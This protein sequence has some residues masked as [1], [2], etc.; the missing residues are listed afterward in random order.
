MKTLITLFFFVVIV[1]LANAQDQ[2]ILKNGNEISAKV[3]EVNL[4][5]IK[6]KKFDNLNGP[7]YSLQKS[8]IFM[9]K[10][11]NGT[12]DVINNEPDPKNQKVIAP[13]TPN[14]TTLSFTLPGTVEFGGDISFSSQ[15]ISGS[16][17]SLSLFSFNPYFGVMLVK[18]LELGLMPGIS[19]SSSGGGNGSTNTTTIL[20]LFLAPAYNFD[21]G[22]IYPFIEFLAGYNSIG[23]KTQTLRGISIGGSGGLKFQMGKSG[24]LLFDITYL[25]QDYND[26]DRFLIERLKTLSVGLGARFFLS[27]KK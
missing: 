24:L 3:M 8:E 1:F 20:N 11:E 26:S 23:I 9:I 22:K 13:T 25:S 21:A 18:G 16:T 17:S 14:G 10:Y 19:L 4:A 2:I 5:D 7:S 12:K 15:S 6:Y 27:P